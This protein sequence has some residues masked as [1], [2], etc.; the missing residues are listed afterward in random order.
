MSRPKTVQ[1]K[2]LL[3]P[4]PRHETKPFTIDTQRWDPITAISAASVSTLTEMGQAT[5]RLIYDP[6][7]EAR[8]SSSG[9]QGLPAPESPRDGSQI[10]LPRED[11]AISTKGSP[12]TSTAIASTSA[13]AGKVVTSVAKGVLVTI[14][15]AATEGLR[16]VPRLYGEDVKRH[17]DV[18]DFKS[19]VAVAGREFRDEMAGAATDIVTYTYRGKRDEGPLGVAKGLA[20]GVVSLAAKTGTAVGGLVAYPVQGTYR[21]IRAA[22][23]S[24]ARESIEAAKRAEGQWLV[25]QEGKE[26]KMHDVVVIAD[27]ESLKR[28]RAA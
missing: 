9:K 5:A 12:S 26:A 3:T 8:R 10:S 14:P 19:G 16:A 4:E 7:S 18:R 27:F 11:K 21:G 24:T 23:R 25:N 13:R 28:S 20:K 1:S 22:V 15:L 6:I 17:A 2:I